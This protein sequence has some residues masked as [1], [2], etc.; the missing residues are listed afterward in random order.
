MLQRPP[1]S[2][3]SSF[4]VAAQARSRAETGGAPAVTSVANVQ[5]PPPFVL[6]SQVLFTS[7]TYAIKKGEEKDLVK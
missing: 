4:V 6:L 2:K 5:A 3:H 7:Q 1:T